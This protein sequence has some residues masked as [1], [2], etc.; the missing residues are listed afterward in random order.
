MSLDAGLSAAKRTAPAVSSASGSTAYSSATPASRLAG[1]ACDE[2]VGPVAEREHGPVDTMACQPF[3]HMRDH[4]P[5]HD[6]QHLLGDVVG[7]RPEPR[8]LAAHE[9]DGVH[10]PVV[11]VLLTEVVVVVLT[12]LGGRGGTGG[13]VVVVVVEVL[14]V[15]AGACRRRGA[16]VVV[17]VVWDLMKAA[18]SFVRL[19]RGDRG[20][21]SA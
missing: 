9:D 5:T 3:D 4:R 17:V 14:V 7:E 6:G 18:I 20:T 2:G 15:A 12:G 8:S 21:R 19:R 13:D 1:N 11:V 16:V 10:Q